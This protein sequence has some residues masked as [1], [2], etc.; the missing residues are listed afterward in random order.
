MSIQKINKIKLEL[1]A[2]HGTRIWI[3][4]IEKRGVVDFELTQKAGEIPELTLKSIVFNGDIEGSAS[5]INI[6]VC[7]K[8]RETL[9]GPDLI[10]TTPLSAEFREYAVTSTSVPPV[11]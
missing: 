7:A 9:K 4:D 6:E 3:D 8:C 5:V 11:D 2:G 1:H 10:E